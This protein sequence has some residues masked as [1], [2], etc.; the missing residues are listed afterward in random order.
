MNY[1]LA[2]LTTYAGESYPLPQ[3]IIDSGPQSITREPG[4]IYSDHPIIPATTTSNQ[5][6]VELTD[7][8]L[9]YLESLSECFSE[10]TEV[11]ALITDGI[12]RMGH[13]RL[14]KNFAVL[15]QDFAFELS[16]DKGY[17]EIAQF[18]SLPSLLYID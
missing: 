8:H 11:Q 17:S 3:I 15:L 14:G 4:D 13:D 6:Q 9:N 12:R 2:V 18:V 16:T 5:A 1:H 10:D 7:P